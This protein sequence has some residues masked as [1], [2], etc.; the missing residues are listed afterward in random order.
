MST[1]PE[2]ITSLLL[3]WRDGDRDALQQL[4]PLI[5]DELHRLARGYLRRERDGHTLQPTSLINEAY[6]RLAQQAMPNWESRAH[7]IGFSAQL[8]RQV[9]VD[10]YR[11]HKTAKRGS[12]QEPLALSEEAVAD[13][14]ATQLIALDDALAD[15][16]KA[17]AAKARMIELRY[18]GGLTGKEIACVVNL[19]TATITREMRLAEAWLANE[20]GG[21][22]Q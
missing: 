7:F 11:K 20:L 12:G 17:D 13:E 4:M 22:G 16:A 10:Y 9:L 14:R 8:M 1:A 21:Q 19:S 18:F 6:V 15:L 5:Y 3:R 2:A